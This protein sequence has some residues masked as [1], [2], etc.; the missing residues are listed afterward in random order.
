MAK[1][2][3]DGFDVA[4]PQPREEAEDASAGDFVPGTNRLKGDP[5]GVLYRGPREEPKTLEERGIKPT[6]S[7]E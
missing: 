1:A 6:G 2:V 3:N 4:G 5:S 7:E